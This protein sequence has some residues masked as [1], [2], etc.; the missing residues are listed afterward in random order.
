MF[1]GLLPQIA[2]GPFQ[3]WRSPRISSWGIFSR[4]YGTG[5]FFELYPGLTSWATL[6]RPYGTKFGEDSS[7]TRSLAPASIGRRDNGGSSPRSN[8]DQ[9]PA[10]KAVLCEP[11]GVKAELP[12]M[13]RGLPPPNLRLAVVPA[14]LKPEGAV[15][16]IEAPTDRMPGGAFRSLESPSLRSEWIF[17]KVHPADRKPAW[18]AHP[19][20]ADSRGPGRQ[21]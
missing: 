18:P 12:R 6:S 2:N 5:S 8:S 11:L 10:A 17:P 4:P 1:L 14:E 7:H 16:T 20:A 21:W 13:K 3:R 19:V 15:L 9:N